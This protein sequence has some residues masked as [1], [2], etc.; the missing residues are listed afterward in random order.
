MVENTSWIENEIFKDLFYFSFATLTGKG[1]TLLGSCCRAVQSV[2]FCCIFI[3]LSTEVLV[4]ML[5]LKAISG[6]NE[7]FTFINSD[8]VFLLTPSIRTV[9]V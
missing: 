6:L 4:A 5:I 2:S 9:S 8:N 3:Q 1:I 7:D